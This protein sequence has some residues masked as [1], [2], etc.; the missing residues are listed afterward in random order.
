[1]KS[2]LGTGAQQLAQGNVGGAIETLLRAPGDAIANIGGRGS[3]D[4]GHSFAGMQARG[5][6][7]Q[8][9]CWYC[10]LPSIPSANAP[11]LSLNTGP[12]GSLVSLP[13]YYVQTSNLPQRV[14]NADST[15]MNGHQVHLPDSYAV[16]NLNLGL[17]MDSKNLA[18][19][20][21]KAWQ[22]QILGDADPTYAGN[23]GMWG[24]PA[25]YKKTINIVV[26][27]VKKKEMLTVRYINCWPQDPSALD[28]VS[29]AAEAL[30]Q[31][32]SFMVEDV[33]I[34]V[35]NDKGLIDN[36]LDT[37][38]GYALGALSG[39]SSALLNNLLR[40]V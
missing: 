17:F 30:V 20:W 9:W 29:G 24:L 19:R 37:A 22:G 32:V 33:Q 12:V 6:A 39:A 1:M 28:L 23:Q 31:Q 40:R 21:L 18:H 25:N 3:E 8:N 2:S 7:L 27:D 14:I 38:Q 36:L 15:S 11:S 10:L 16:P 13:W 4:V 5:D 26:V 34:T 35:S